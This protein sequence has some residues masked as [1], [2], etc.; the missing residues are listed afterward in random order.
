MDSKSI[1]E[2]EAGGTDV[3]DFN[4]QP[5]SEVEYLLR[6]EVMAVIDEEIII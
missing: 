6:A 4:W 3:I 1:S 2:I 5:K